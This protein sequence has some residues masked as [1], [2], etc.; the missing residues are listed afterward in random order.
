MAGLLRYHSIGIAIAIPRELFPVKGA[1]KVGNRSSQQN[2]LIP[3]IL[4][5]QRGRMQQVDI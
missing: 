3:W 1:V 2:I 5:E 4:Q